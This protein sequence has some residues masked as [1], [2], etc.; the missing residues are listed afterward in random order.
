VST[1]AHAP[2][3]QQNRWIARGNDRMPEL[4]NG[5]SLPSPRLRSRS[6][7]AR[8]VAALALGSIL[9]TACEYDE[10]PVEASFCDD[11]CHTLR[12]TSCDQ[13]PENCVRDCE[14]A[15]PS[16]ACFEL[17]VTLLDCYR[18]TPAAQLVC[19][20]SGFQGEI[21]PRPEIC[22][23]ERDALIECE[24]PRIQACIDAC[25]E[26]D[27]ADPVV[28]G[29]PE[30][31][32]PVSPMPCERLCWTIDDLASGSAVG[33][34]IESGSADLS[35]LGA[36]LIDCARAGARECWQAAE[37]VA[38]EEAAELPRVSWTSVFFECAP[39]DVAQGAN[40][41]MQ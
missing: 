26:L 21:R 28:A 2:T 23:P 37:S 15:L 20:D 1:A 33:Q 13:E 5:A 34:L 27:A 36:P 35:T 9:V 17:Q 7:L 18:G 29:P 39:G 22:T 30:A 19:V 11:W 16:A 6:R 31:H 8:G 41:L 10:Y 40:G 24:A 25:R 32:C 12:R 4:V 3:K 38:P 14:R